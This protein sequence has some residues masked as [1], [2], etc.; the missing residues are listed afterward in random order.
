MVNHNS[1]HPT[2]SAPYNRRDFL[3]LATAVAAVTPGID[4]TLAGNTAASSQRS[5][6]LSLDLNGHSWT[7]QQK[8]KPAILPAHVPGSQYADLLNNGKIPDPDFR[9]QNSDVQWVARA[10]W[11][12]Q[13]TFHVGPDLLAKKHV[14]LVCHGLDTLASVRVN[15]VLI[16]NA[17]NMY[18]IWRFN[19]KG[20]VHAGENRIVIEFAP[21][22]PYAAAR[23]DAYKATHGLMLKATQSWV[24]KAPYMWG[25]D[26]C[27]PLL[28]C[29]IWKPIELVGFDCRIADVMVKQAIP[30]RATAKLT[31]GIAT[32]GDS[33]AGLHAKVTVFLR[34][35]RITTG[36]TAIIRRQGKLILDIHAPELWWPN[37]MGSQP[38]YTIEIELRDSGKTTLDRVQ[39]RIGLRTIAFINQAANSSGHLAVNGVPFFSK[40]AN[41]IPADNLPSR[42]TPEILR[43]FVQDAR[44]SHF[45]VLRFWGGGYYEPQALFDACDEMGIMVLFEFK[46]ANHFYPVFD[47]PWMDNVRREVQEQ[48]RLN[49]HHPCIALW[50]G[51]NEIFWFKGFN[52]LFRTT[53]GGIVRRELPGANYE[54]GS[55]DPGDDHDLHYW[56]AWHV[57]HPHTGFAAKDGFISEFGMQSFPPPMTVNAYTSPSDRESIYSKVMVYHE[58]SWG[59]AG[60]DSM[61]QYV[62]RYFGPV[63]RD[64]E[65]ALWLT[66][67]MQAYVVGY[68]VEHWR[69]S[70]PRSM[71]SLIWQMNDS[72]PGPTWSMI[73]C[74]HRWKAMMYAARRFFS[75]ILVS[76][77]AD[78]RTGAMDLWVTSDLMEPVDGQLAWHTSN[79]D[80]EVLDRGDMAISI[81]PRESRL[82]HQLNYSA[83]PSQTKMN[84]LLTWTSVRLHGKIVSENCSFFVAPKELSLRDP[85]LSIREVALADGFRVTIKTR[86]PALW[87]WV[88]LKDCDAEYSDNFVHLAARQTVVIQV[89]PAKRLTLHEFRSRLQVRSLRDITTASG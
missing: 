56:G 19:V 17:D 55:G 52:L 73:D 49:R 65:S 78:D 20:I 80:G 62:N 53:I 41:W 1:R 86:K 66:Q 89:R 34:G 7:M 54:S 39:R 67:I 2:N 40:G 87:L 68:G 82:C 38:L 50:S 69:R 21:T 37:G 42:V 75:P 23:A 51:N 12:Y 85:G 36:R 25:W 58:R 4:R 10:T 57:V 9:D 59:R 22:G 71:A 15:G 70:M 81:S 24:R 76:G 26:W 79:L 32:E 28:T 88:S 63:P 48:V 61:M 13:R 46:F 45:N 83:L 3:A 16:G 18:R 5:A 8:G 74:Y 29:G 33:N 84:N 35:T 72:W 44:D 43:R 31:I 11:I 77:K 14:Q 6:G 30:D 60:I 64:F 47:K 27:R